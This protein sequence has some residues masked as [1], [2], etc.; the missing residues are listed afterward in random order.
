[1]TNTF[2]PRSSTVQNDRRDIW[3]FA[4]CAVADEDLLVNAFR[5]ALS[6]RSLIA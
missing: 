3:G 2:F 6:R 4:A 1:M 5:T